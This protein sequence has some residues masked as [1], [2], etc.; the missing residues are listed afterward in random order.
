MRH[1]IEEVLT[2]FSIPPFIN[3][4]V[5]NERNLARD[6]RYTQ[7][8]TVHRS[9][10]KPTVTTGRATIHPKDGRTIF[11]R[12]VIAPRPR[13]INEQILSV[14]L[15]SFVLYL[16]SRFLSKEKETYTYEYL[17]NGLEGKENI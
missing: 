17:T 16:A 1:L 2:N 10:L 15:S 11:N 14:D 7:Y 8:K 4:H 13:A 12:T 9:R 6:T 3:V 5:Q